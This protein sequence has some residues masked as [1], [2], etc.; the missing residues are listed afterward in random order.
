M[1]DGLRIA[2]LFPPIPRSMQ[3]LE[4]QNK[5]YKG[6]LHKMRTLRQKIFWPHGSPGGDPKSLEPKFL[7][8]KFIFLLKSFK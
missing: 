1:T 7:G 2:H 5:L 8:A 4:M 6:Y 3:V